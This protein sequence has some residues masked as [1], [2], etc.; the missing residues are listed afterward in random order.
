M[1][2]A[3]RLPSRPCSGVSR[4]R[5]RWTKCATGSTCQLGVISN[6]K[7]LCFRTSGTQTR[8]TGTTCSGQA[9]TCRNGSASCIDM[10]GV[11]RCTEPCC[12]NTDCP[13]GYYCSLNGPNVAVSG[14][15]VNTTPVC[16]VETGGNG[17]R[18]AGASCTS[19]TQC[20]SEL[21]D[22][23]LNVCVDV[24]CSDDTCPI[25]LGCVNSR[26]RRGTAESFGRFCLSAPNLACTSDAVCGAGG[27]CISG[28]CMNMVE[29]R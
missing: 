22:R 5:S 14:G 29:K 7:A 8:D 13:N 9:S 19:N 2:T 15:G 1:R 26:V 23:T 18:Q 24:C 28:E 21:C 27:L 4:V 6:G 16:F 11:L 20:A 17:G 10:T 25:G 3:S 12:T